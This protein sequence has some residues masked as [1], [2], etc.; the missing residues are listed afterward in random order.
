MDTPVLKNS[1]LSFMKSFNFITVLYISVVSAAT[2]IKIGNSGGA[3]MFLKKVDT[4]PP[5][6]GNMLFL[7]PGFFVLLMVLMYIHD[8]YEIKQQ[9]RM[10]AMEFLC[11]VFVIVTLQV[12][13]NGV[14]LLLVAHIMKYFEGSSK[15]LLPLILG[16]TF[17]LIFD[18]NACS[19]FFKITSF[20][21]Y[22]E[23]YIGTVAAVLI[24]VK[25][26]L[27]TLNIIFFIAYTILHL[28][29][30]M[31]E[32]DEINSLNEQLRAANTELENF[33]AESE[34]LAQT[35]ERNR[36]ARE[37]HDTLGHTLT[38]IIA[39]I[40]AAMAV[41]DVSPETLK[42]YLSLVSDVARQGMTDVRRS[43]NELRPDA[44][45]QGDLLSAI[46][47]M[48]SQMGAASKVDITLDNR[49]GRLSFGEDEEK[50][51]YRIIQESIT[52]SI[53]HGKADTVRIRMTR[54]YNLVTITIRDD[55]I[56]ASDIEMGFGLT[57]MK[58]RL[59][60]LG[61]KIHVDGSDGFC[62]VAE[63]PIRWGM[64]ND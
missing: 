19:K 10:I 39:G 11:T 50:I 26:L 13:Y 6:P 33:A 18:F 52:N 49:A 9:R 20:E 63:I 42:R 17:L 25:N 36:L 59:D 44:L 29:D 62:V 54:E 22:T 56:G 53:R 15:K 48:I 55:G 12:N 51:I 35:R 5:V 58:E 43:V 60:M 45:E 16:S 2:I 4:L 31:D 32:K 21:T 28:R 64:E 46:H 57:H 14:I 1:V 61:G 37:I 38:G 27:T 41:A 47:K 23:Y 3:V 7:S 34:K 24:L 8:N 30:Q 40:D